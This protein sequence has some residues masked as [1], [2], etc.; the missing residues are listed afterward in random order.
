MP[1]P[2]RRKDF[3]EINEK[4][5]ADVHLFSIPLSTKLGAVATAYRDL[6]IS[7]AFYK[8][9]RDYLGIVRRKLNILVSV[10]TFG[11][12][13]SKAYFMVGG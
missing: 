5:A 8:P 2:K 1:F 13:L 3:S 12:L 9:R 7:K 10:L 4:S 11:T 6:S